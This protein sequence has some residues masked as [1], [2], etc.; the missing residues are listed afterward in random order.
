MNYYAIGI[1]GT[2]AKCIEA[3]THLSAAGM[4]PDG[5][6]Y[7]LFV[8]PDKSNGSLE[9][10]QIMLQ[11]YIDCKTNLKLGIIDLFKTKI[12]RA[13]PDVW[14]PFG[15]ETRPRLDNFF[16]YSV[17]KTAKDKAPAYLFDVLYS[18]AEKETPLDMGFRGRPSIGAAV[19]GKMLDLGQGEP[20]KTFR[21]RIAQDGRAGTGAK[22]FFFASIFGGTGAAGFPTIARLVC[23][24][25]QDTIGRANVKIG[26]ALLLPYF[27]FTPNANDNELKANSENFLM[28]TQVALK[29]YRQQDKTHNHDSIYFIGDDVLNR[30]DFCI[31]AGG[32]KNLPHFTELYGA[33]A[34]VDFFKKPNPDKYYMLAREN[35]NQLEW[36]DL[37]DGSS[38][39]LI[40]QK[41][42]N[43]SRFAFSYL[44]VYKK[45]LDELEKNHDIAYR[46]P[47]FVDFFQRKNIPVDA[48]TQAALKPV[49][50]YCESFLK[51]LI[52]IQ[53]S[54]TD[55]TINLA[56]YNAFADLD[57]P[58][59]EQFDNLMLPLSKGNKHALSRLWE[60][61]CDAESKIKEPE[62]VGVGKFIHALYKECSK[63]K[64]KGGE[65]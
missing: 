29:Y 12:A 17:L 64:Q 53:T 32:Q 60:R 4:L 57:N 2:G 42:N 49:K 47:W 31:G 36:G 6:L 3:L 35:Q 21:N 13:E 27:S 5:E 1:G 52:G 45:A 50:D 58:K 19:M 39:T 56:N 40:K 25:L 65:K 26:G 55:K 61:M 37:P 8:D 16:E 23:N 14:S 28:T 44:G 62:A 15:D 41:I 54:V 48:N 34:A 63:N 24:E 33:L 7:V 38:G 18:N 43:L 10:A 20:W 11:N 46:F 59:L 22:I 9:R 51:W 30:V